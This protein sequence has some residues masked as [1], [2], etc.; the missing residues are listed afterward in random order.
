MRLP[1]LLALLIVL[2]FTTTTPAKPRP[3]EDGSA[4][5]AA[6][7]MYDKMV[8]PNEADKAL[9]L[10]Y[11]TNTRERALA[12]VL[13]KCD[14]AIANLRA[15]AAEKFTP[16]AADDL[17][18][19]VDATTTSDINAARIQVTGDTAS[20][21]FPGSSRPTQM[22]RVKGE[23]KIALKPLFQDLRLTPHAFR[24]G[25][26]HLAASTN[27]IAEKIKDGQFSSPAEAQKQLKEK[28]ANAFAA[29]P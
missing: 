1:T 27:Q 19:A 24:Q 29:N 14:G 23:W 28:Y 17:I 2:T 26:L 20:V 10:Y 6:L 25:F 8:G 5:R 16:Q 15:Q 11:A 13:A 18:R 21:M 9:P 12:E 4:P 3:T 22:I 7:L